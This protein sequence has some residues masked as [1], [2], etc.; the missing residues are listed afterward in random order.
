MNPPGNERAINIPQR[1]D[2]C[3]SALRVGTHV[4]IVHD[5]LPWVASGVDHGSDAW[6]HDDLVAFFS[7]V[8]EV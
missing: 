8:M 1:W 2:H 7:D 5:L 3:A 6:A 4:L